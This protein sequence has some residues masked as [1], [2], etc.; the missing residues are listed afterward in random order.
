MWVCVFCVGVSMGGFG[1]ERDR[2]REEEKGEMWQIRIKLS[3]I[4]L[5]EVL[6]PKLYANKQPG[7]TGKY[8]NKRIEANITNKGPLDVIYWEGHSTQDHFYGIL[9]K[10]A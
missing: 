4:I 7:E 9:A 1:K 8:Y 10:N 2:D 3:N 6:I 5:S